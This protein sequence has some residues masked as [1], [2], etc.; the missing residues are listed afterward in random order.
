M[1]KP[2]DF[3]SKEKAIN[4]LIEEL[5]VKEG[6]NAEDILSD[7]AT[8]NELAEEDEDAK[9]YLEELAEKLGVSVDDLLS[10]N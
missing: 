2:T 3:E 9:A 1:E 4:R 6:M 8:F 5:A 7:I 10:S